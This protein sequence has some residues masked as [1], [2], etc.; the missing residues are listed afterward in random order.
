MAVGALVQLGTP[1]LRL[2][3][4]V[5]LYAGLVHG[6]LVCAGLSPVTGVFAQSCRLHVDLMAFEAPDCRRLLLRFARPVTHR[7]GVVDRY[8]ARQPLLFGNPAEVTRV[9]EYH[10]LQAHVLVA[11]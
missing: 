11:T 9:I 4:S 6:R 8:Q 10:G 7:T 2:P 1:H 5:T 3:L